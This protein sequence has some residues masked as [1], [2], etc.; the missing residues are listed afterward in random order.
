[1]MEEHPEANRCPYRQVV[2][3]LIA[4]A[5]AAAT[6][7]ILAALSVY[8]PNLFRPENAP[9]TDPRN[10]WPR[11]RPGGWPTFGSNDR[12]RWDAV[13]ALV[14]HGT[15]VIGRRD[16]HT[17]L[18]SVPVALAAC[19]STQAAVLLAAAR[20]ARL[21]SDRGIVTEDGWK[22]VDKVLHPTTLEF[23]ST[24][25][26]LLTVLMAGE[27]WLLK[28]GLG[29]S[30]TEYPGSVV[31]T[32]VWTFNVPLLVIYLVLL[33]RLAER[34]GATGWGR[35]YVIVCACFATLLTPFLNTF[36]NHTVATCT[37]VIALYAAVRIL[38]G[39]PSWLWF[40]LAGFFAGF[41]ACNET[42]AT[43]YAVGL[44]LLLLWRHPARTLL[45]F[46]PLALVPVAALFWTNYLELGQLGLAY[47]EF[48]G[49]WYEYEG[50]NWLKIPGAA[51]RGIDFARYQGE[52][53][54]AYAFHL[55]VGH[56]GWFSLTPI[57]FLSL[58]GM[59]VAARQVASTRPKEVQAEPPR[60]WAEMA[61]ANLLLSA[62]VIVFYI[63]KTD[64]YGGVSS[65][66]R[67]LMW[68]TPLWLLTMLPAVDW[69]GRRRWGRLVA[70][71][72]L[73]LS[74]LSA[75]F[76]TFN[77]WRHPWI[78]QWMDSWGAIPY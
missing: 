22:T 3:L 17:V 58:A 47:G 39:S 78:Y 70:V 34:W 27:Y 15:W 25:P 2:T 31:H 30:I 48:G 60:L 61:V 63:F 21:D 9:L 35:L 7:R 38:E 45:A 20:Q 23:Y 65:G 28:H 59:A 18:C 69:L 44:F 73:M 36:N 14:D 68:L 37:A 26:P 66:A 71:V 32:G 67:W 8:D 13:R 75:S 51:R 49:P 12:S 43:A 24:K 53:H 64:N 33:S 54:A 76:P 19:D 29:W 40:A 5:A 62:V 50:S 11:A 74:V 4:V 1:M 42:P 72:L 56:H 16:R 41:T 77:P 52:T 57:F 10:P 55:L 6:G 46:V